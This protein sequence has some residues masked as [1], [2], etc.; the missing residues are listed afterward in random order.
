MTKPLPGLRAP[1]RCVVR[2]LS[3]RRD[4]GGVELFMPI[5]AIAIFV[6]LGLVVDGTGVLNGNSRATYAA[7]EAARAAGQ[8][9]DPGEAIT[10]EALVV[11]PDA[12]ADAA[13]AYLDAEGLD[14]D[15]VVSGDGK[16]ITVTAHDSY[17]P[18]FASLLGIDHLPVSGEGKATLLHQ[19]GG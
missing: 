4:A 12:A 16:T 14:G 10:G 9:I 8:Q 18:L 2:A 11:D 13:Q 17:D 3:E 19:P 15:V 7:Q 5:M 6:M 1:V